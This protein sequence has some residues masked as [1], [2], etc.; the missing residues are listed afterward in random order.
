MDE[1]SI[2]EGKSID[3]G[4]NIKMSGAYNT[5][6]KNSNFSNSEGPRGVFLESFYGT[7]II[8]ENCIFSN[9]LSVEAAIY[10]Y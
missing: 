3:V 2:K 8:F 9:G 6:I 10:F 4:G 7:Y 1:L 5:T